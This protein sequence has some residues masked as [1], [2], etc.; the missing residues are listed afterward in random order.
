MI[1]HVN[2]CH[3]MSCTHAVIHSCKS[4][5]Q[6]GAFLSLSLFLIIIK[7]ETW[8]RNFCIVV[9][10]KKTKKTL[11]LCSQTRIWT[12]FQIHMNTTAQHNTARVRLLDWNGIPG[13]VKELHRYFRRYWLRTIDCYQASQFSSVLKP[14]VNEQIG[15]GHWKTSPTKQTPIYDQNWTALE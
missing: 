13:E 7:P 10:A 9:A 11:S 5:T 2:S 15:N 1:K 12:E 6:A 3:V 4:N 8:D 14:H